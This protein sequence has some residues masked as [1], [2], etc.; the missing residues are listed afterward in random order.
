MDKPWYHRD[1]DIGPL[2]EVGAEAS[3][4]VVE[5]A[6]VLFPLNV[7]AEVL[8]VDYDVALGAPVGGRA[9]TVHNQSHKPIVVFDTGGKVAELMPFAIEWFVATGYRWEK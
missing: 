5:S 4:T 2:P 6:P 7:A 1:L 9:L 3:A 8:F